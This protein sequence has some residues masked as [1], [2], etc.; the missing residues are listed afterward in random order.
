MV[1][2]YEF[3][4]RL[5][6]LIREKLENNLPGENTLEEMLEKAK[7]LIKEIVK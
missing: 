7:V 4:E 5:V 3:I 2:K 1:K 6:Y